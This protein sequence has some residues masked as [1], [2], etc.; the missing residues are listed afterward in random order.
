MMSNKKTIDQFPSD[1]VYRIPAEWEKHEAT[2]IGWPHNKNDWPGKIDPIYWVYGEIVRKIAEG[3]KVRIIVESKEEEKKA[4]KI[5]KLV[6][7]K[8]SN[9]EF[10]HLITNRGWLRDSGPTFIKN[11]EG[12]IAAVNFEFNAWA[13]YS[14]FKK[15]RKV[16]KFISDQLQIERFNP[17]HKDKKVVL[18]GGSIDINGSGTLITTEECLMEAKIQVMILTDM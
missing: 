18:E 11:N 13:K 7:V 10:F 8:I 4:K 5:L 12:K 6:Y 1:L 17:I 14:N 15:D 3:E 9:V 2:W 16:P